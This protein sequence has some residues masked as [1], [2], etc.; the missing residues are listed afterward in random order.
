MRRDNSKH[1]E[2]FKETMRKMDAIRDENMLEV[3]PEL[4]ELYETN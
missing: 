1:L 3:F 2:Q 4:Q